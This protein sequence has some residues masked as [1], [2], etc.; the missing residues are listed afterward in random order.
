MNELLGGAFALA[1]QAFTQARAGAVHQ[2]SDELL[3][4]VSHAQEAINAACAAQVVRIAQFACRG[5]VQDPETGLWSDHDY[6]VGH[7]QEFT[8]TEI[9][10]L[11]G[12]SPGS[13]DRRVEVA[14]TLARKLPK[15]LAAMAAGQLDLWRASVIA[16]ELREAS[17][18]VCAQVEGLIFP[19]LLADAPRAARNRVRR[20]LLKVDPDSLREKAAKA[21]LQRGIRQWAADLPGM[22]EWAVLLPAEDAARCWAAIDA[23]AH[24]RHADDPDTPLEA[25]RADA[26]V[27][28]LLGQADVSATVTFLFPVHPTSPDDDPHHDPAGVYDSYDDYDDDAEAAG[29]GGRFTDGWEDVDADWAEVID[30]YAHDDTWAVKNPRGAAS[31]TGRAGQS[32]GAA[33]RRAEGVV[34]GVDA[35][36]GGGPGGSG[37]T[38]MGPGC[39]MLHPADEHAAP[40]TPLTPAWLRVAPAGCPIP[41]IGIIPANIVADIA[42]QF[43]TTLTRALLDPA[44]GTLIETS[45]PAYTPPKKIAD[46]VRLRDGTCRF[47]GCTRIARRCDLDHVIPWPNGPTHVANLH[48]LCRHH[49]RAKHQAGWRLSMTPDGVCTWTSPQG[50]DYATYPVDHL[51][52]TA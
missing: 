33:F 50:Q 32:G 35:G 26:L 13:A 29:G 36:C 8:G 39:G 34:A 31:R 10:P 43:G 51:E 40:A 14:A 49:H 37:Y 20:A 45:T 17:M 27:D 1:G 24:Q 19:D 42:R 12:L 15:T 5:M 3:D 48:T 9:G 44:T 28:L 6:G 11:L 2:G 30:L 4:E 21:R 47:P 22:T 46:H 7:V 16:E 41:G 23:L 25:C 18:H 52:H 38:P